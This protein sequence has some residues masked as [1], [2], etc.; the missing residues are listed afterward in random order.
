[1]ILVKAFIGTLVAFV[2]IDGVWIA[3]VV[4]KYY[5]QQVGSLMRESPDFIASAAFYLAYV[6]G[7]VFLAVRPALTTGSAATAAV[8]GAVIGG[9]AYGTYTV[10]NY[11]IFK[12][13][14]LGLLFSDVG[15]GI[16]LTAVIA[17]V[18]FYTARL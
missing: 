13:W 4:R 11:A 3:L 10:T 6:A 16:F 15:W 14:S 5:E 8:H 2:V 1:M 18:G 9:L 12:D 7:V 17:V